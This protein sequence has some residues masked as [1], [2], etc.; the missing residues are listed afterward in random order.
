MALEIQPRER[1]GITIL[2]LTGRIT[3]GDE[4]GLLREKITAL[5][6]AGACNIVLDMA[7]VQ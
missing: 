7:D 1:E 2:K 4:A 5:S 3:V 6:S